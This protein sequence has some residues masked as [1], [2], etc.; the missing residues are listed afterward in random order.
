MK[1]EALAW[2]IPLPAG[3]CSWWLLVGLGALAVLICSPSPSVTVLG[4]NRQILDT[5]LD[6]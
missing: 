3:L 1:Q 2:A 6:A 5:R 4:A